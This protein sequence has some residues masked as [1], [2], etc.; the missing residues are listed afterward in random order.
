MTASYLRRTWPL[1]CGTQQA[2]RQPASRQQQ[3]RAG[4]LRRGRNH[5]RRYSARQL[6]QRAGNPQ[7]HRVIEEPQLHQPAA[8][9]HVLTDPALPG[10]HEQH[11]NMQPGQP[12]TTA[13]A[14]EGRLSRLSCGLACRFLHDLNSEDVSGTEAGK[15]PGGARQPTPAPGLC[16]RRRPQEMSSH[17]VLPRRE[18]DQATHDLR[19]GCSDH[20][21]AALTWSGLSAKRLCR[22]NGVSDLDSYVSWS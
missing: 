4:V 16:P 18:R 10:Q 20:V 19:Q 12:R 14:S 1:P 11:P 15:L 5:R 8:E 22:I 7:G 2:D 6:D 3:Q 9:I 13:A 21:R 17:F